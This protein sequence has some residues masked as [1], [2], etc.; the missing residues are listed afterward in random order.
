MAGAERLELSTV[1]FGDRCSTIRTMPLWNCCSIINKL[2]LFVKGHIKIN[3]IF[4]NNG[5][6]KAFV[7]FHFE[8]FRLHSI[9]ISSFQRNFDEFYSKPPQELRLSQSYKEHIGHNS[10]S[11]QTEVNLSLQSHARIHTPM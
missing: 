11:C 9:L 7:M 3:L 8:S 1:G 2:T 6:Y 4:F 10:L 5:L